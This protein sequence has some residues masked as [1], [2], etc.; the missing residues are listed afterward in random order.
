[1]SSFT[2]GSDIPVID[3]AIYTP[4]I[5][6]S[7]FKHGFKIGNGNDEK[8]YLAYLI[9]PSGVNPKNSTPILAWIQDGE[10]IINPEH[11]FSVIR[12]MKIWKSDDQTWRFFT[13]YG[14][15]KNI[16]VQ[17]KRSVPYEEIEKRPLACFKEPVSEELPITLI[18]NGSLY[19]KFIHAI[20]QGKLTEAY[21]IFNGN[22][23]EI[24]EA[25]PL[26]GNIITNIR[27]VIED[28]EALNWWDAQKA[29]K[30]DDIMGQQ[31]LVGN[32]EELNTFFEKL[33]EKKQET[34]VKYINGILSIVSKAFSYVPRM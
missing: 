3:G 10:Q 25:Y 34:D 12:G 13:L 2:L 19:G 18:K 27:L 8:K 29:D 6:G 11:F 22:P 5:P 17:L 30:I 14:E 26:L 16:K 28:Q 4:Q 20:S 23:E 33:F 7:L 9:S 1:M 15:R 32:S 21:E 24:R 31:V